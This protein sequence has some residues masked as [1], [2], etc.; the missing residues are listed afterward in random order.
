M[1]AR[2]R[3]GRIDEDLRRGVLG[4]ALTEAAA[5]GRFRDWFRLRQEA[6]PS[7]SFRDWFRLRQET[8]E[9]RRH[10]LIPAVVVVRL[11]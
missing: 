10:R 4:G 11:P 1:E 3:P 2:A 5:S 6:A 9:R 8:V 7:G